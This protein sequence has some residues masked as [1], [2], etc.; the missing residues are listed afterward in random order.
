[1]RH[2]P[3]SVCARLPRPSCRRLHANGAVVA[4]L[5]RDDKH[6]ICAADDLAGIFSESVFH[7]PTNA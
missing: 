3:V 7:A 6:A 5:R 4:M 1:M 2:M